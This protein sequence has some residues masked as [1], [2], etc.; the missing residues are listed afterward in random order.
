[1]KR[2]Q[3]VTLEAA[4]HAKHAAV[5]VFEAFGEVMGVGIVHIGDGYGLKVNLREAPAANIELP[6]EVEGVPIQIE[7]VGTISTL[8]A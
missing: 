7:I 5:R 2:T 4:R 1:M 8:E 3:L 6:T